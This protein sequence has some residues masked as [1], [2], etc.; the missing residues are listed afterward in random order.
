MVGSKRV[1]MHINH[2][3]TNVI[4]KHQDNSLLTLSI[5][6][7]F[8]SCRYRNWIL[9]GGCVPHSIHSPTWKS[10][11]YEAREFDEVADKQNQSSK[12]LL[13]SLLSIV[14]QS[15]TIRCYLMLMHMP[16]NPSKMMAENHLSDKMRYSIDFSLQ[17]NEH[18]P[19]FS[20]HMWFLSSLSVDELNERWRKGKRSRNE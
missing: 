6:L 15:H 16:G 1:K 7:I 5:G 19:H 20:G 4:T 8:F 9:C 12:L 13:S 17:Q 2:I 3:V 14:L 10:P 18:L 11:L